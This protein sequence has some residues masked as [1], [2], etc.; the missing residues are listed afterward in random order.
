[1]D[2]GMFTALKVRD[3]LSS[4]EVPGW[5]RFPEGSVARKA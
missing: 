2:G 3:D 4:F 5:Y 1:M